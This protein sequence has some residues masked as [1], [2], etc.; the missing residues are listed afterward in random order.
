[1]PQP[2]PAQADMDRRQA[3]G[4]AAF[5]AQLGLDLRQRDIRPLLDQFPQQ[6]FMG[7]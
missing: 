5:P 1:M 4:N 2:E 6:I 7:R 3:H